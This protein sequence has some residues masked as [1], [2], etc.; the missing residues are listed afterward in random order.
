M[1]TLV[2]QPA[3]A[4]FGADLVALAR[5][6]FG[7][8]YSIGANVP[9]LPSPIPMPASPTLPP[10]PAAAPQPLLDNPPNSNHVT[11]EITSIITTTHVPFGILEI[12]I[13][14][15]K[16]CTFSSMVFLF[17]VP[18]ISDGVA[19]GPESSGP[20][21]KPPAKT[22]PVAAV[23]PAP[24]VDTAPS[25]KPVAPAAVQPLVASPSAADA[26]SAAPIAP[27]ATRKEPPTRQPSVSKGAG[28]KASG[29]SQVLV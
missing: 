3:T 7:P 13:F 17:I 20:P 25:T 2:E 15:C 19:F 23:R 10:L 26:P 6:A 12:S 9:V 28:K 4:K 22:A 18:L 24:A 14:I 1:Q 5:H 11:Q 29:A 8:I 21:P 27:V 16:Y